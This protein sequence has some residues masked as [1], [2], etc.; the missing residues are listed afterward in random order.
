LRILICYDIQDPKRLR[1]VERIVSD[2]AQ[3]L[4]DSLY[5]GEFDESQLQALQEKLILTIHRTE[6]SV[7]YYPVCA[8]DLALRFVL[9]REDQTV[10]GAGWLI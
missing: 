5:E 6:D 3:R 1:K 9:Q 2:V 4:Q 8:R 10:C 7:R